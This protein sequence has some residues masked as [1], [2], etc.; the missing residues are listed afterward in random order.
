MSRCFSPKWDEW[1]GQP[2]WKAGKL[3]G[4]HTRSKVRP[5]LLQLHV[6]MRTDSATDDDRSGCDGK[7]SGGAG[8]GEEE[9]KVLFGLPFIVSVWS[10][11]PCR[12]VHRLVSLQASRYLASDP[13]APV[14]AAGTSPPFTLRI[15]GVNNPQANPQDLPCAGAGAG[16]AAS[17]AADAVERGGAEMSGAPLLLAAPRRPI[18]DVFS[19]KRMMIAIDWHAAVPPALQAPPAPLPAAASGGA[20]V[21]A[22]LPPAAPGALL[23]WAGAP[24]PGREHAS[25]A[26]VEAAKRGDTG[27]ADSVTLSS[28]LNAYTREETLDEEDG[29]YCPRCKTHRRAISKIEPWKLPDILVIHVKRFLCSARWREKIRTR[30][31]FPLAAFDVSPWVPEAARADMRGAM[32]YDL[33]A[34]AN[35][36]GGM[37]GGHYTAFAR[38]V[39]C[40]ADGVEEAASSF[41]RDGGEG[42]DG[43]RWLHFDDDL[44]EEVPANQLVTEAA[45]VLFYRRRRLTPS[46]VINLTV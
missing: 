31:S 3:A 27:S 26:E 23:D 1:Y 9:G 25:C 20:P 18:G 32:V 15:V 16:T 7:R 29:W 2:E 36:L 14:A 45:Y 21:A 35:H 6:V 44:V 37:T 22:A 46:N 30:V 11:K 24:S 19:E 10:H 39:P 5:H 12:Y 43:F 28:C 38:A 13:S 4:P 33:F 17:A 41:P 8:G 34:V 40:D 42:A